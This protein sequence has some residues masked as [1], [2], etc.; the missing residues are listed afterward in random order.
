VGREGLELFNLEAWV[1]AADP[2]GDLLHIAPSSNRSD[3]HACRNVLEADP[4]CA[5]P[6]RLVTTRGFSLLVPTERKLAQDGENALGKV[7]SLNAIASPFAAR[8]PSGVR[9]FRAEGVEA[10]REHRP[11]DE[12]YWTAP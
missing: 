9:S 11:H 5:L 4:H 10:M 3:A 1:G 12:E 7:G 6:A 2:L 8:L